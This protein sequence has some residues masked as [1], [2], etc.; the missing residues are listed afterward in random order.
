MTPGPDSILACPSCGA[1]V[2]ARSLAS[3]NTFGA[4]L[5]SDGFFDAPMLPEQ[6]ALACCPSDAHWFWLGDALEVGRSFGSNENEAWAQAPYVPDLAT[7]DY[8]AALAAGLGSTPDLEAFLRLRL[9][10]TSNDVCRGTGALPAP[11]RDN[12]VV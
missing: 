4:T 6:P 8:G 2:R 11:D 10:W 9:W 12:L 1:L 7:V 3:G 5:W